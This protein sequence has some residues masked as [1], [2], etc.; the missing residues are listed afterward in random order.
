L[1]AWE[2]IASVLRNSL[3]D[4]ALSISKALKKSPDLEQEVRSESLEVDAQLDAGRNGVCLKFRLKHTKS[5]APFDIGFLL[6]Q[7]KDE[8]M[9]FVSVNDRTTLTSPNKCV[10]LGSL[11]VCFNREPGNSGDEYWLILE[12]SLN[13]EYFSVATPEARKDEIIEQVLT[14]VAEELNKFCATMEK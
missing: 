12:D 3:A 10:Y 11:P 9:L 7:G 2:I 14:G 5:S 6:K 4:L 1:G 8:P 13:G